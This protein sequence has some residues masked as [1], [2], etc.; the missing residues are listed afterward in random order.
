ML[1]AAQAGSSSGLAAARTTEVVPGSINVEV[2][3]AFQNQHLRLLV[4]CSSLV[5]PKELHQYLIEPRRP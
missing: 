4:K 5:S 3:Q 1:A 2:L